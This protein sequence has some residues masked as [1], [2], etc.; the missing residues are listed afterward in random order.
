MTTGGSGILYPCVCPR[1]AQWKHLSRVFPSSESKANRQAPSEEDE[2][3]M[4]ALPSWS[5]A[6]LRIRDEMR[7][8]WDC[9]FNKSLT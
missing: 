4:G 6:G 1:D 8:Q 9:M 5:V 2:I 7:K 3:E